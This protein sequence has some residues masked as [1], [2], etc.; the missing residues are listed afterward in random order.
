MHDHSAH[1]R[2]NIADYAAYEENYKEEQLLN[3]G[4][5][6]GD[7]KIMQEFI[8]QLTTFHKKYNQH[9]QTAF[10]GDMGVFNYLAR[11]KYNNRL[12]HG[13]PV[14]TTFKAFE[15]DNKNCWFKHK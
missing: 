8:E 7:I 1:V 15:T 13:E 2:N 9:N 6:G 4:I 12:I 11:T 14:N 5:I 10:T 3:C